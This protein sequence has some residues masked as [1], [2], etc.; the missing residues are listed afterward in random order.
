MLVVLDVAKC[1]VVHAHCDGT[2]L[3]LAQSSDLSPFP[4]LLIHSHVSDL[5]YIVMNAT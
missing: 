2:C 1:A 5:I 4:F 3:S